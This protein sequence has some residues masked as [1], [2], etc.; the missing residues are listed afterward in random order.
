MAVA[1][2][3]TAS[4]GG[5][6]SRKASRIGSRLPRSFSVSST[7]R[8]RSLTAQAP[9]EIVDV[10]AGQPG[11]RRAQECVEVVTVSAQPFEAKEGEQRAAEGRL[12]QANAALEGVRDTQRAER[13]LEWRADTVQR[14]ADEHDL[15]CRNAGAQQVEQLFGDELERAALT[16]AFEEADRALEWRT[17]GRPLG[18]E[19]AF[20]M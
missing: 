9:F 13:S 6:S 2:R 4:A 19:L 11:K 18:E 16:C 8:S 17:G 12:A 1:R 5:A 3:W 15:L 7:T 14:R 10:R 20:E